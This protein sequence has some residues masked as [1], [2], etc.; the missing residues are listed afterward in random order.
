MS[1]NHK[2]RVGQHVTLAPIRFRAIAA[3]EFEIVRLLPHDGEQF[4]YRI[5]SANESY[6]RVAGEN[7]LALCRS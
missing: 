2:F 7:Q 4:H 5:K 1:T 3:G 6:D